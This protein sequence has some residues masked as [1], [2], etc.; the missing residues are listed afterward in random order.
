MRISCVIFEKK[1]TLP[2]QFGKKGQKKFKQVR[3]CVF[4]L[5]FLQIYVWPDL[6]FFG[7]K[8]PLLKYGHKYDNSSAQA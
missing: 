6:R 4:K 7:V 3:K 2:Y 5:F 8:L 1:S